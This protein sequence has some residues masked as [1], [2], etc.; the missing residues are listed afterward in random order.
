MNAKISKYEALIDLIDKKDL[1]AVIQ[2]INLQIIKKNKNTSI[3]KKIEI[4]NKES[5]EIKNERIENLAFQVLN[6]I[7]KMRDTL[8]LK[9]II[10]FLEGELKNKDKKY[11]T[12]INYKDDIGVVFFDN[13]EKK[14]ITTK[15]ICE[16]INKMLKSNLEEYI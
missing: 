16:Q 12:T 6:L 11:I 10:N 4:Q 3:L 8:Y 13:Y 5:N 1:Q 15:V 9:N 2:L 14:S 7:K